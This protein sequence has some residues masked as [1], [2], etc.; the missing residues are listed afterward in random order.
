M[1]GSLRHNHELI[2]MKSYVSKENNYGSGKKIKCISGLKS[3][4]FNLQ[5]AANPHNVLCLYQVL[6]FYKMKL[7]TRALR[8]TDFMVSVPKCPRK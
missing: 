1:G 8:N 4:I 2:M 3:L 7:F 5:S 6:S